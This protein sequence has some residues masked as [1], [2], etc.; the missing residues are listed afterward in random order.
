M[1]DRVPLSHVFWAILSCRSNQVDRLGVP[2]HLVVTLRACNDPDAR[3]LRAREL[4]ETSS[5]VRNPSLGTVVARAWIVARLRPLSHW[6]YV[7]RAVSWHALIGPLHP[8]T[9]QD[10]VCG[11]R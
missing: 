7:I 10:F 4:V 3:H 11:S 1:I 8:V 9:L 6:R 2:S 5:A